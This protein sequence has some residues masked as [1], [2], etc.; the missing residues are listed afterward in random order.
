MADI[1]NWL[2]GQGLQPAVSRVFDEV[3]TVQ[4]YQGLVLLVF[5]HTAAA[6][7][8]ELNPRSLH[9]L[10]TN[11]VG[12]GLASAS[13]PA[14]ATAVVPSDITTLYQQ[15]QRAVAEGHAPLTSIMDVAP[16]GQ[17]RLPF[18]EEQ[19][20]TGFEI[21]P[22]RLTVGPVR[23]APDIYDQLAS[24]AT[25]RAAPP[26]APLPAVA[27]AVADLVTS[28]IVP[29]AS[30]TKPAISEDIISS[31]ELNHRQLEELN[32]TILKPTWK[33]L[34]DLRWEEWAHNEGNPF[35]V[36]ITKSNAMALGVPNYFSVITR[37][38]DLT[39]VGEKLDTTISDKLISEGKEAKCY[40]SVD[41]FLTDLRQIYLNAKRFNMP[42]S[43]PMGSEYPHPSKLPPGS[44]PKGS[45]YAMAFDFEHVFGLLEAPTA[46][47]W[48]SAER[49]MKIANYEEAT[50][51][52]AGYTLE[53]RRT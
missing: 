46:A 53:G 4:Q 7:L 51:R 29:V 47:A 18:K 20:A 33:K 34:Y 36:K 23:S 43:I 16:R 35:R 1:L 26:Q 28:D 15:I 41:E 3:R 2:K 24:V 39:R 11:M 10:C 8:Q 14:P 45:V 5:L 6:F 38:M 48:R 32:R 40:R 21:F 19:L 42:H 13:L 30:A 37:A 44:L 49:T 52:S 50:R 9:T 31:M 12:D 27:V 22:S 25:L 17:P